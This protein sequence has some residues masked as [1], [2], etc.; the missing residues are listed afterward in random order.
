M[1]GGACTRMWISFAPA[2]RSSC[3]IDTVLAP[4]RRPRSR[5]RPNLSRVSRSTGMSW[6]QPEV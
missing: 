5:K 2:L 6:H 1:I 3:T 4:I